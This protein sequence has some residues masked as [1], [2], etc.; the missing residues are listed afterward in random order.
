MRF[1]V[2]VPKTLNAVVRVDLRSGQAAVPKQLFYGIEFC[3]VSGKVGSKTVSKYMG[4]FLFCSGYKRKV[5]FY[6]IVD[7]SGIERQ[8]FLAQEEV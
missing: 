8:T 5:F 4:T 7:L 2:D 1:F 6:G 3:P